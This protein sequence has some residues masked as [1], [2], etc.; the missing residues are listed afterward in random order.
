MEENWKEV[1]E[2]GGGRERKF[3]AERTDIN[4]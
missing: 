2:E 1:E 4:T 3:V